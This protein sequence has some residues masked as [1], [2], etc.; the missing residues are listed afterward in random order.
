[1]ARH[2]LIACEVFHR[3]F[4]AAL[5]RTPNTVDAIFVPQGLHDKRAASMAQDLQSRLDAVDEAGY[6]ALL[7]G[8]GLC[9]NGIAGVRA[10]R[11]PVVVTRAHDCITM[12]LGSKERYARVFAEHPGSYYLTS[13]WI[14]RA[15]R[16][17]ETLPTRV[18]GAHPSD[19]NYR[20]YVERFGEENAEYLMEAMGH[21]KDR[22]G[23]IVFI[24]L[25]LGD[26]ESLRAHT[27]REAERRDLGF[28][29]WSGELS[30]FQ[31]LVDGPEWPGDRYLVVAPGCTLQPSYDERVVEARPAAPDHGA[32]S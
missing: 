14:E 17:I 31:G 13:G 4:C 27:R 15:R 3:E 8:Y 22:Y 9:N 2:C 19:A 28:E 12:F 10:G 29:E 20:N 24:N 18:K 30:L 5:A 32:S 21:W 6:D 7:L 11:T 1:M 23:R 26:V 25:G 16:S